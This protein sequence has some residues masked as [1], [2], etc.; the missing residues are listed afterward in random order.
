VPAPPAGAAGA[1]LESDG[2]VAIEA[3]D[4]S[5]R[6]TDGDVHWEELPGYGITRSA[7]TVFL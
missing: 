5:K 7:M 1:F 4:T 3:A 2:Y 6:T